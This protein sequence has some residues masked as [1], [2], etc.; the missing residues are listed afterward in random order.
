MWTLSE[1][2]S[3]L[4]TDDVIKMIIERYVRNFNLN[5]FVLITKPQ[6][7]RQLINICFFT[8]YQIRSCFVGIY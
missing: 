7:V 8:D 1:A 3:I 4:A 2:I 6:F 5:R